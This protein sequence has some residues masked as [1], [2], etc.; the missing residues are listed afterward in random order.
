MI[1]RKS[2]SRKKVPSHKKKEKDTC[3]LTAVL[4]LNGVAEHFRVIPDDTT[5]AVWLDNQ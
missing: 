3:D 2:R 4:V 1:K 5:G